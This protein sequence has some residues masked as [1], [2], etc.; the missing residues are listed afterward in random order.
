MGRWFLTSPYLRFKPDNGAPH[1][2]K[3]HLC[4]MHSV[5]RMFDF[6]VS[7]GA[8]LPGSAELLDFAEHAW[9]LLE[10]KE[11]VASS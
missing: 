11:A 2:R 8:L 3:Q 6:A 10:Q 1:T 4:F 7:R 9:L 5:K